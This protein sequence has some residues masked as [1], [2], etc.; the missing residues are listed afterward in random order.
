MNKSQTSPFISVAK[1]APPNDVKEPPGPATGLL[2]VLT[3]HRVAWPGKP[4]PLNPRLVS[5]TP[6]DFDRQM[7]HLKRHY[8]VLSLETL[9]EHVERCHPLPKRAVLITFD[10]AYADL[11]DYAIPI[12]KRHNLSAV[13]FV[14]TA[15]PGHPERWFWWDQL[16]FAI[17]HTRRSRI[18]FKGLEEFVLSTKASRETAIRHVQ[19]TIKT[20][21]HQMAQE[22]LESF[23]DELDVPLPDL[24]SVLDWDELRELMNQGFYLGPH[25][26]NHPILSQADQ[27]IIEKEIKGSLED[28]K[29][30]AD[31]AYPV[32]CAPNGGQNAKVRNVLLQCGIR[33]AF[34]TRDGHNVMSRADYR[35]L[36][37]TNITL[38]TSSW[39]FRLRLLRGMDKF[40][41]LRHK[42]H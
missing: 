10:D 2:R 39:I 37:R 3:F 18:R 4:L 38:R 27:P 6:P 26:R 24:Q 31:S 22:R 19:D 21:P 42:I 14:P 23:F 8:R 13:I 16:Y 33:L 20:L 1:I 30:F 5:A 7:R 41:R 28:L 15:Y 32:F 29:L 36:S 17:N 40:D 35:N 11:K 34:S 12:L 25:T 9:F